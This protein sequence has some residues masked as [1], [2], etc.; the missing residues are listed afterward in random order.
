[1]QHVADLSDQRGWQQELAGEAL[2]QL[3]ALAIYAPNGTMKTSLARTFREF[4]AGEASGDRMFPGR[5]SDRSITDGDGDPVDP[6]DVVVIIAYDE[7]L[8]PTESR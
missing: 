4:A 6:S 7:E 1:V 5:Q 2:E 8:G 3:H